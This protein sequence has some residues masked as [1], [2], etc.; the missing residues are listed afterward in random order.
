M[1]QLSQ[2]AIAEFKRTQHRHPGA[3]F[4]LGVAAGGCVEFYYTMAWDEAIAP[5][6][7][8]IN[9][10]GIQ[11]A[12][13]PQHQPYLNGLTLDYT[14]DLMGGGFRFHNPNAVSCCECGNSFAVSSSSPADPKSPLAQERSAFGQGN[15]LGLDEL[16][17]NG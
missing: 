3:S 5:N 4:R 15:R 11:V 17:S 2:A 12:I 6:D 9:C 10:Q 7:Q 8:I 13:A 16:L 14:E 1:I